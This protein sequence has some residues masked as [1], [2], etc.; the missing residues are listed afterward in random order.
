MLRKERK[1]VHLKNILKASLLAVAILFGGFA[2][3]S[4]QENKQ[5]N[6]QEKVKVS[7]D[8]EKAIKKIENGKTLADKVKATDDYVKKYPQSPARGQV[9]N[10]LAAQIAQVKDDAQIIQ[11][12]ENYLAIFTEPAEADLLLPTLIYSYSAAKRD[13]DAFATA[14]KYFAR[15]PEEVSLRYKLALDGLNLYRTGTKDFAAQSRDYATQAIA[16]IEANKKPAT[17]SDA[18]WK[19]F[20]TKYLAQLYQTLGVLDF[21]SGDKSKAR[22]NF[23]KATSLDANDINSWVLLATMADEEYQALAMKY[24]VANAGAERDAL[25]KQANEKLD[26]T[27]EAF[28][29]VVALTEAKPEAK[30]IHDQI[31][32]T[33]E[34]YYQYRHKNLDGLPALIAK[35]KK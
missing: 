5:E 18:G 32:P 19:D 30:Q 12:G 9:V 24:N 6:K 16:L 23:E 15:H 26:Q 34:S 4:A 11:Y 7:A 2:A 14:E 3:V 35:Y 22:A 28:A 21:E 20:Q 13:K 8:E 31:R 33:L 1:Q 29:R 27:I 17:M 10:Y 25:L